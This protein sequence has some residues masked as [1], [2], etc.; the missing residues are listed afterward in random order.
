M[1]KKKAIKRNMGNG[2]TKECSFLL[3]SLFGSVLPY[4]WEPANG[5]VKG[6]GKSTLLHTQSRQEPPGSVMSKSPNPCI[7]RPFLGG[8]IT[9]SLF[10][11][12]AVR[13]GRY[14]RF[15]PAAV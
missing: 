7:P 3:F 12:M 6:E 11:R 8:M 15:L 1:E 14:R 5:D 4:R 9:R 2:S 13:R 10:P